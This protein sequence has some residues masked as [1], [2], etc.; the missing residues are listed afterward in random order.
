MIKGKRKL[1]VVKKS[2]ANPY[3]AIPDNTT[4]RFIAV[5]KRTFFDFDRNDKLD[6]Y[7]DYCRPIAQSAFGMMAGPSTQK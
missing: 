7:E 3:T 2:T 5:D 4:E 6:E 1:A